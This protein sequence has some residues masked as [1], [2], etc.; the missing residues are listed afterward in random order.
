MHLQA[1]ASICKCEFSVRNSLDIEVQ[2]II[3]PFT[4]LV[5]MK[6][7]FL[8][9]MCFEYSTT[10]RRSTHWESARGK[11]IQNLWLIDLTWYFELHWPKKVDHFSCI[12][13]KKRK[14]VFFE[15]FEMI[16]KRLK[17]AVDFFYGLLS[18][19]ASIQCLNVNLSICREF[20]FK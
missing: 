8:F 16:I 9:T 11:K 19:I 14:R 12:K 7:L 6:R 13:T 2:P 4:P 15:I 10:V 3:I 18:P 20:T 1:M 17:S 5:Y